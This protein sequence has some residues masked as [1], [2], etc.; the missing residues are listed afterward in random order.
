MKSSDG[1][2]NGD[3]VI[4]TVQCDTAANT[5]QIKVPAPGFAL[6]F[7]SD[8]AL[9]NSEPTTTATFA[10]TAVTKVKNTA[11]IDQ[12]VLAT[13]NGNRG[14][15]AKSGSTSFGSGNAGARGAVG[16]A[17]SALLA[18]VVGAVVAMRAFA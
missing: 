2:L 18:V 5:G 1:R 8:E 3:V 16:P 11:T 9:E 12:A 13:S 6:V 7:L 17:V 14:M 4:E 10:T 15:E